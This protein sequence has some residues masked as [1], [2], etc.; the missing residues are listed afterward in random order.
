MLPA[1][2]R[3]FVDDHDPAKAIQ[4]DFT[5]PVKADY[6][7]RNKGSFSAILRNKNLK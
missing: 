2:R 4:R 3:R 5:F 1:L 6:A 7:D